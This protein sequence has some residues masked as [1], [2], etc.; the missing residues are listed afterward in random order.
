VITYFGIEMSGHLVKELVYAVV[1]VF[2]RHSLLASNSREYHEDGGI[3]SACIVEEAPDDLLD[4]FLLALSS[5]GLVLI[6]S[7]A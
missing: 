6:G 2:S 1:C 7:V 3:D 4:V 5:L